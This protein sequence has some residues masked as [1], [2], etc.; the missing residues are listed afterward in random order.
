VRARFL[1]S[2]GPPDDPSRVLAR[3]RCERA[4]R[5]L[6]DLLPDADP[7]YMAEADHHRRLECRSEEWVRA[8][9]VMAGEIGYPNFKLAITGHAHHR[10]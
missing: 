8:V 7:L 4:I 10:G 9:L 5:A 1:F 2:C 3:S 6:E